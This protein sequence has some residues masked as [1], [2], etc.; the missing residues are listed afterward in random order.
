MTDG[1]VEWLR[2]QY[3]AE[4]ETAPGIHVWEGRWSG[5]TCDHVI[6][7]GHDHCTCGV[8]ARL[9]DDVAAKRSILNL[10]TPQ[11]T[12]GPTGPTGTFGC[13]VCVYED[14]GEWCQTV[15]LLAEPF[16]SRDSYRPEWA[17]EA[18]T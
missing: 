5:E 17:P 8:P 15:R 3:D 10:H 6:A 11:P 13:P 18:T 14:S 7:A 9:L 1:L 12:Y 16:A 2:A 4:A